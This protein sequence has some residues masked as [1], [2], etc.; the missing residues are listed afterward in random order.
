[1]FWPLSHNLF[2][3]L[4]FDVAGLPIAISEL[5]LFIVTLPLMIKLGDLQT[6]FKPHNRNWALIIPFG[7]VLGPLLSAGRGQESSLPI[8]LVVPCLF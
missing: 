2:G 7:A 4:N 1:L 3:I 8:L 6:L 5:V